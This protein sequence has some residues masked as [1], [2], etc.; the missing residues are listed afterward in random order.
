MGMGREI[1]RM[2]GLVLKSG[3]FAFFL[4]LLPS[5]SFGDDTITGHYCFTYGDKESLMEAKELTHTLAIRNAIESY[6]VYIESTGTIRNFVLTNDIIQIISSGYLKNIKVTDYKEQGRTI[7]ETIQAIV[8][9]Q[10]IEK[11][12]RQQVENSVR[13]IEETGIENNGYLKIIG[14]GESKEDTEISHTK[15]QIDKIVVKVKVLKK[16]H[17]SDEHCIVFMTYYD[18]EGKELGTEK[19][20]SADNIKIR[21]YLGREV[22]NHETFYPGEIKTYTFSFFR[23]KPVSYKIWLYKENIEESKDKQIRVI[24]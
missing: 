18:S 16:I 11:I 9:P 21:Q 22:I 7:C 24:Q 1:K 4:I 20:K 3:L 2:K 15:Y 5:M 17:S 14:I 6:R 23:N 10:A 19:L 8:S 12:I 13:R